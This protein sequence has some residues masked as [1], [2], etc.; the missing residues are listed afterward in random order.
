MKPTLI[1][2]ATIFVTYALGKMIFP[3]ENFLIIGGA[4]FLG[5]F[6]WTCIEKLWG[7]R[8]KR[9][10]N[11]NIFPLLTKDALEKW[12]SIWGKDYGHVK[13]ITLYERPMSYPGTARHILYF[14]CGTGTKEGKLFRKNFQ[15]AY[16]DS[17]VYTEVFINYEFAQEVYKSDPPDTFRD[18]WQITTFKQK[19][20]R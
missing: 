15:G 9:T 18:D 8:R 3:A 6:V 11:A 17:L 13:K 2:I 7:K 16:G 4:L 1:A 20:Q 12:G 5:L 14:K 10:D 19:F